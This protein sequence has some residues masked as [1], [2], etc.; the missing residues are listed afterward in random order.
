LNFALELVSELKGKPFAD[1]LSK[2]MI[3]QTWK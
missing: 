1:N 3:V 2:G